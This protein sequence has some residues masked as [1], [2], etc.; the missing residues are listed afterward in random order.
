MVR[1]RRFIAGA[2]ALGVALIAGWSIT[3]GA[4][5]GG[6]AIPIDADDLAHAVD[7]WLA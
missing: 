2:A 3:V 4:R 7:E 1:H 6:G 5:Q